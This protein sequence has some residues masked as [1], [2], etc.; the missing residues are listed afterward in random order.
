MTQRL[1]SSD[2]T[3][4]CQYRI[5][6]KTAAEEEEVL[7]KN[8]AT[9]AFHFTPLAHLPARPPLHRRHGRRKE[10]PR[11]CFGKSDRIVG[12]AAV[13]AAAET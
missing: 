3:S 1:Q 7:Y 10:A 11:D 6:E 9:A 8:D 2:Y 13:A 5:A 12:A 4:I